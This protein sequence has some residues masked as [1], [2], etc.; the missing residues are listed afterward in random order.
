VLRGQ[1]DFSK[2]AMS[3]GE[4]APGMAYGKGQR[5]AGTKKSPGPRSNRM[6]KKR[7]AF[8]DRVMSLCNPRALQARAALLA[9]NVPCWIATKFAT[10]PIGPRQ[11]APGQFQ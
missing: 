4:V 5:K 11:L 2:R 7:I 3:K 9:E 1:H 8:A 6:A 10:V